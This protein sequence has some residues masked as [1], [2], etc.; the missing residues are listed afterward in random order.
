MILL[1]LSEFLRLVLEAVLENIFLDFLKFIFFGL[2]I[3]SS[4]F[5]YFDFF[6]CLVG[7]VSTV[8]S[9]RQLLSISLRSCLARRD[10]VF[11][12]RNIFY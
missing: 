8:V 9:S 6:Y 12:G 7:P 4:L 11:A 1:P 5:C 3:F 10:F 2:L